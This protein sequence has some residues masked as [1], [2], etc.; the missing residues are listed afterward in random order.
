MVD[1][2]AWYQ[3]Y[4]DKVSLEDPSFDLI[5]W[6]MQYLDR[7]SQF[8]LQNEDDSYDEDAPE[9]PSEADIH[10]LHSCRDGHP[11]VECVIPGA[12]TSSAPEP[13]TNKVGQID[14]EDYL[15]LIPVS[16]GSKDND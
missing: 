2:D 11:F 13:R 3:T 16:D 9:G 8:T 12:T 6:Y 14:E 5:G 10:P 4:I 15:E 7:W 1:R